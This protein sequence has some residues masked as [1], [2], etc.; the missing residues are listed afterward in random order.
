MIHKV[1]NYDNWK[2]HYAT[3]RREDLAKTLLPEDVTP[4]AWWHWRTLC[5]KDLIAHA[6][7]GT[8]GDGPVSCAACL[9]SFETAQRTYTGLAQ[10][11]G[12]EK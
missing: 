8:L 3:A 11:F 2:I 9:R 1:V 4:E 6:V 5:G 7:E 10:R 12:V